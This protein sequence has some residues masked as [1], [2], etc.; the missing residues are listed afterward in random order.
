MVTKGFLCC[1]EVNFFL[2]LI[3]ERYENDQVFELL[4][5]NI[6]REYLDLEFNPVESKM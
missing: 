3:P 5:I 1:D 6:L 2:L 4:Y